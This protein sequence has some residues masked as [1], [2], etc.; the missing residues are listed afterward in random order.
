MAVITT[1]SHPKALWPG[2][3]AWVMGKYDKHPTFYSRVFTVE[4]STMAY[5][6]DVQFNA[7]PLAS[8]KSEGASVAYSGHVQGGTKR[9]THIAYSNGFIV[10]EEEKDDNLYLS[11]AFRRGEMLAQSFVITKEMV[12][13]NIFNRAFNTAYTGIDGKALC[14]ADHTS[15]SGSQSNVIASD[16]N[17]T[18]IE[19]M[20]T[21]IA[22]ATNAQGHPIALTGKRLICAPGNELNAH[23]ILKSTLQSGTA[24]ND[25]NAIRSMGLLPEGIIANPYHTDPDAWFIQTNAL[26]GLM[27]FQRTPYKF[28][29][30]SDFDTGNLRHKGSERYSGGWTEWR[31]V[32]GSPGV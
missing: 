10:T 12:H 20:L 9:Y 32:W 31:S 30:D 24:N 29:Q 4:N 15:D 23:R 13:A 14:V 3:H 2:V 18:A 28:A 11:R 5:E 26:N 21:A 6:E 1:G 17:E 25:V 16:L 7:F 22:T 8:E 19:D 27:S